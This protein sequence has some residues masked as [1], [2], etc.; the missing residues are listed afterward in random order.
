MR[1]GPVP[2]RGSKEDFPY[3]LMVKNTPANAGDVGS[4]PGP[5]RSHMA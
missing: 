1:H 5:S 4:T 2:H 3:G